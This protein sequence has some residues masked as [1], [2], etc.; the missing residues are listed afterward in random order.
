MMG[1]L[2]G[3]LGQVFRVL[4]MLDETTSS[5]TKVNFLM[6]YKVINITKSYQEWEG[7]A[8]LQY[9]IPNK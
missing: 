3:W 2:S 1:G 7:T 8:Q 9:V 5:D 6:L 4:E